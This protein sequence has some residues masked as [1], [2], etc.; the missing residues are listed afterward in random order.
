ML[1]YYDGKNLHSLAGHSIAIE[2]ADKWMELVMNEGDTHALCAWDAM[3]GVVTLFSGTEADCEKVFSALRD[4]I[5][6]GVTWIES[7][8]LADALTTLDTL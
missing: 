3:S 4:M 6:C 2:A 7:A 8:D 5:K 1:W